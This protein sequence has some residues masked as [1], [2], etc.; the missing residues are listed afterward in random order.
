M[1]RKDLPNGEKRRRARHRE[2]VDPSLWRFS[3]F[4]PVRFGT[5]GMGFVCG[6][7][8]S[9]QRVSSQTREAGEAE[10]DERR[11]KKLSTSGPPSVRLTLATFFCLPTRSPANHEETTAEPGERS[12]KKGTVEGDLNPALLA[13]MLPPVRHHQDLPKRRY[14]PKLLQNSLYASQNSQN[15]Q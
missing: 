11:L 14:T 5:E 13:H 12:M 3:F 6:Y 1:S 15:R 4:R 2:I 7:A 9:V 10:G 8:D